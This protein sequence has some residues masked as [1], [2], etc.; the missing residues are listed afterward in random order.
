[1]PGQPLGIVDNIQDALK[2]RLPSQDALLKDLPLFFF[3]CPDRG[4]DD[5]EALRRLREFTPE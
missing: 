5:I 1:M 3:E 4:A 2:T